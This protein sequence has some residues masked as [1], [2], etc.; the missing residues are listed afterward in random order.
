MIVMPSIYRI[1]CTYVLW[2][3]CL[4][5]INFL[6]FML[7]YCIAWF[8]TILFTQGDNILTELNLSHNNFSAEGGLIIGSA[9]GNISYLPHDYHIS[10]FDSIW[11]S[12]LLPKRKMN[13]LRGFR[14]WYIQFQMIKLSYKK[15][16]QRWTFQ[17]Y[18][19]LVG[20]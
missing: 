4:T 16:T 19:N 12:N 8:A 18:F 20:L 17:K 14:S 9:L 13:T 1:Y 6:L 11:Y 3:F 15:W 7:F 10:W 2:N 5:V